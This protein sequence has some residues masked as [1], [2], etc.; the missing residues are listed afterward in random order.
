MFFFILKFI[1]FESTCARLKS[2]PFYHTYNPWLSWYHTS[3]LVENYF[4]H[5][6]NQKKQTIFV[7]FSTIIKLQVEAKILQGHV[8]HRVLKMKTNKQFHLQALS[9]CGVSFQSLRKGHKSTLLLYEDCARVCMWGSYPWNKFVID[10]FSFTWLAYS[11]GDLCH[12]A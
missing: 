11:V 4:Y 7:F 9:Q 3:L 8:H 5:K 6:K 12:M 1:F 10:P 2:C